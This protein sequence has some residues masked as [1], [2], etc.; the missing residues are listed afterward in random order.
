MNNKLPVANINHYCCISQCRNFKNP[1]AMIDLYPLPEDVHRRAKCCEILGIPLDVG[2]QPS[3]R[4]CALHFKS[5]VG[6]LQKST[7]SEPP[8][9]IVD[10]GR[11]LLLR[12][13]IPRMQTVPY[14]KVLP[15]GSTTSF[16]IQPRPTGV[17]LQNVI[18]K[19]SSPVPNTLKNTDDDSS[20]KNTNFGSN[21]SPVVSLELECEEDL[22]ST[23]QLNAYMKDLMDFIT[24][25]ELVHKLPPAVPRCI[26]SPLVTSIN[27]VSNEVLPLPDLNL[28]QNKSSSTV[29]SALDSSSSMS[30]SQFAQAFPLATSNGASVGI[31]VPLNSIPLSN[32]SN[33]SSVSSTINTATVI[34]PSLLPSQFSLIST[35]STF[36]SAISTMSNAISTINNMT[37]TQIGSSFPGTTSTTNVLISPYVQ[38]PSVVNSTKSE[39]VSNISDSNTKISEKTNINPCFAT[40]SS[41]S[42][43][44]AAT[45]ASIAVTPILN[46]ISNQSIDGKLSLPKETIK[47]QNATQEAT[48]HEILPHNYTILSG[49]STNA[50]I[51][52]ML[53]RAAGNAN[54]PVQFIDNTAKKSID[55]STL[56]ILRNALDPTGICPVT[57]TGKAPEAMETCPVTSDRISAISSSNELIIGTS[58]SNS[59][60]SYHNQLEPIC[61]IE[62]VAPDK[63]PVNETPKEGK[64]TLSV[65]S[66]HSSEGP[67]IVE[68]F[69]ATQGASEYFRGNALSTC[70]LQSTEKKDGENIQISQDS[71][72]SDKESSLQMRVKHVV[73]FTYAKKH[74][75]FFL[76]KSIPIIM[77]NC[78][79]PFENIDYMFRIKIPTLSTFDEAET[80]ILAN[81]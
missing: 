31:N 60:Q 18:P 55:G 63:K 17:V 61:E 70:V 78:Q 14:S 44:R 29:N 5:K 43:S 80:L 79:I 28:A 36:T 7:V 6:H 15:T 69:G 32:I 53:H 72:K 9:V 45:I 35:N 74:S 46:Q 56:P 8:A 2:L 52:V 77:P 27:A 42:L 40:N 4:V 67:L 38:K 71:S 33:P 25:N 73:K 21:S 58:I 41:T 22:L 11:R 20:N 23:A 81:N 19:E 50:V 68:V 34:T 13:F 12:P 57:T 47:I 75:L 59:S 76:Q 64:V 24:A 26:D 39:Y 49:T 16:V 66:L 1:F 10:D 3:A 54:S 65:S 48:L 62:E 37:L 51:P 30:I